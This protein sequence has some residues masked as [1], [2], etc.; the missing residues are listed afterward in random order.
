MSASFI[1]ASVFQDAPEKYDPS[2]I[3]QFFFFYACVAFVIYN[4]YI[5][6]NWAR[7]LFSAITVFGTIFTVFPDDVADFRAAPIR[8][9]VDLLIFSPLLAAVPF[10]FSASA[11]TWFR[12][13]HRRQGAVV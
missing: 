13:P 5:G 2:A 11:N 3:V 4:I 8:A 12:S 1:L 7:L 9:V 6:R 10:L